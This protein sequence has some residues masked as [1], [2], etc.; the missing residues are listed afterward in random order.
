VDDFGSF[1][2]EHFRKVKDQILDK[3]LLS[4]ECGGVISGHTIKHKE[5]IVSS[6][7]RISISS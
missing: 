6:C 3:S 5:P 2:I 7:W 4:V 1:R